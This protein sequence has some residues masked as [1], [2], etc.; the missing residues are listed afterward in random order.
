MNI[1]VLESVVRV[2]ELWTGLLSLAGVAVLVLLA[3][4]ITKLIKI[5]ATIA[6]VLE[7]AA[8]SITSTVDKLPQTMDNVNLI[9]G[10]IVDITDDVTEAVSPLMASTAE[11]GSS[12]EK[13][14]TRLNTLLSDIVGI[15][16]NAVHYFDRSEREKRIAANSS[17][18]QVSKAAGSAYTAYKALKKA[19]LIGGRK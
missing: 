15:A 19:G 14:L 3:I 17:W 1:F 6:K 11:V 8:P 5:F 2:S 13:L 9:V 7:D 18:S 12:A 4:L 10:N 16:H